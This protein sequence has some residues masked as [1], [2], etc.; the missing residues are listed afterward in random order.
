[1]Q[2]EIEFCSSLIPTNLTQSTPNLTQNKANIQLF[3]SPF[4]NLN[5]K[6]ERRIEKQRFEQRKK[7]LESITWKEN[8]IQMQTTSLKL[9]INPK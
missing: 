6:E 9:E 2:F 4:S 8:I 5:F 3:E 1:M 7:E